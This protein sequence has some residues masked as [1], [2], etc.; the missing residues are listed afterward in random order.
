MKIFLTG[1]RGIGKSTIISKVL[2]ELSQCSLGG[3]FTRPD[4]EYIKMYPAADENAAGFVVGK[5]KVSGF[6]E[7]FDTDGVD[8]LK[9]S[10]S[11]DLIILD[12]IGWMESSAEKFSSAIM[13][14]LSSDKN[15]LGVLRLGCETE[16][17]KAIKK[18]TSVK[19]IRITEENRNDIVKEL[20]TLFS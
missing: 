14:I 4:G 1:E 2:A 15:V 8:L 3:F 12:E 6:T 18:D 19:I 20:V 13:D 5:R 10:L 17:A 7:A 9:R 16:L 11:S